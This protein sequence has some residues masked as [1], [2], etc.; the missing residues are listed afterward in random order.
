MIECDCRYCADDNVCHNCGEYSYDCCCDNDGQGHSKQAPWELRGITVT[1]LTNDKNWGSAWK[2]LGKHHEKFDPCQQAADF[3]LLEALSANVPCIEDTGHI[4]KIPYVQKSDLKGLFADLDIDSRLVTKAFDSGKANVAKDI[5]YRIGLLMGEAERE[6][7]KVVDHADKVLVDYFHMACAGEA[8]HHKAI[9]NRVLCGSGN[10][11][12]AWVGWKSIYK[13]IGNQA[14]MD[15][16]EL[17]LE[18]TD[19]AYGGQPWAD[20]AEVL[21]ERLEGTLGPDEFTNKKMFV[22]RAWTLEHNGGCFLNKIQWGVV[23]EKGWHL[24][25]LKDHILDAH[26]ANPTNYKKLLKVASKK[27]VKLYN[28]YYVLQNKYRKL[29]GMELTTNWATAP[30]IVKSVCKRC[31]SNPELGHLMA[32]AGVK[33]DYTYKVDED[34]HNPIPTP[35]SYEAYPVTPDKNLLP[36]KYEFNGWASAANDTE[37]GYY[38]WTRDANFAAETIELKDGDS[39]DLAEI[40]SAKT[41]E[42]IKESEADK[43]KGETYVNVTISIAPV[44]YSK[45]VGYIE[46]VLYLVYQGDVLTSKSFGFTG[47][48]NTGKIKVK[49][50]K[51]NKSENVK[52]EIVY[53]YNLE[54]KQLE[55]SKAK[56]ITVESK[57]K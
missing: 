11:S 40:F 27:V 49:N 14:L 51:I 53:T 3:Y 5:E 9:G 38:G 48:N 7:V 52:P 15:L 54:R 24:D 25:Y 45:W 44:G 37:G 20:A 26:A 8:R 30:T 33:K 29:N 17:F 34:D 1:N 19:G 32:C 36:G 46:K 16:Y 50:Q 42:F 43:F 39:L 10:R 28:R 41:L 56:V 6:L 35:W 2:Y 57:V 31:G 47:A 23:N 55:P 13:A 18:F 12:G 21:Y 4:A 22:D